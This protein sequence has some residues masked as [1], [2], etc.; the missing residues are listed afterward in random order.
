MNYQMVKMN[1]KYAREIINWQYE[2]SLS[3]Y[4]M[5]DNQESL[6]ELLSLD[7]YSVIDVEGNLIG[8]FCTKEA[9]IVP[10]GNTFHV[11]DKTDYLDIG[12]GMNP[13]LIGKGKGYSLFQFGL[14][15][16][17]K[18]YNVNQFRLTVL[19]F[20]HKAIHIYNKSGFEFENQFKSKTG[21]TFF[22]MTLVD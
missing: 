1:E 20:N 16:F 8:F 17:K 5:E 22:V 6:D 11:Y 10:Y 4:N 12:F 13:K 18:N 2:G 14:N 9:A 21:H 19:D 3:I 7:Y 15:Y